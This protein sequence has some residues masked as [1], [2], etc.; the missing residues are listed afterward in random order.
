M[1][2][3][4]LKKYLNL[5][6]C[7][8]FSLILL[9][10]AAGMGASTAHAFFENQA[11]YAFEQRWLPMLSDE[12]PQKRFQAIRA[13]LAYPAWGLPVLRN[14]LMSAETE[15]LN[16][17]IVML[18]GMLGEPTDIPP[19]LKIWREQEDPQRSAVWL[20]AMQR[21]YW[22]NRISGG[23]TPIL[24]SLTLNYLEKD[25]AV[26]AEE[27]NAVIQFQIDNPAR[28]PLF[29]RVSAHFWKTPIQ[30]ELPSKYFWLPAG[31]KI[32][33]NLQTL[34]SAVEHTDDVRLDFR[35]WEVGRAKELL[36]QTINITPPQKPTAPS[37]K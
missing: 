18:I 23:A 35:V 30:E 7:I 15:N 26:E 8:T 20:G 11:R 37:G 3:R 2:D 1:E 29:I 16:W 27:K 31:G 32:E 14:T 12:S 36:H 6:Y 9:L 13:F 22:K 34:F 19:L 25:P 21:L 4:I 5:L 17:Q 33:A 28:S 10:S 24:T